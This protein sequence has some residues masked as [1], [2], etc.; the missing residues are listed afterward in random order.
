MVLVLTRHRLPRRAAAREHVRRGVAAA[1]HACSRSPRSRPRSR[2]GSSSIL[3]GAGGPFWSTFFTKMLPAAVYNTALALLDLS[4]VGALLAPRPADDDLP[5]PRRRRAGPLT[6]V[7][8]A[9][10]RES[11]AVCPA[12]AKS[13]SPGSPSSASSCSRCSGLLLVRLWTMQV[14]NGAA[15]ADA[16]RGEP[17][18]RGHHR[19]RRAAASS[20]A[21]GEPLVTNR[22]TMAVVVAPSASEGRRRAARAALD[23]ARRCPWPT[24]RSASRASS[25]RRS[26][27]ARS[28]STSR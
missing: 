3:L 2:T 28:R 17:R 14:L 13:S 22:P 12:S 18:P 23:R 1:A 27:R 10:S 26:R 21:T 8:D 9:A 11:D 7:P 5:A 15:Y 20:T 24:S 25:R 19:R 6:L 16:G 4:V